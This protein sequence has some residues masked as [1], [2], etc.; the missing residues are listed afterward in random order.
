MT[1]LQLLS[2]LKYDHDCKNTPSF[3]KYMPVDKFTDKTANGLEKAIVMW[4]NLH[5]GMA[6]RRGNTGRYIDDS[7]IVTD[8]LGFKHKLGK[9]KYIPGTGT[10]GTSDVSGLYNGIPLAIEVKI[11]RDRQSPAQVEYGERFNA[12][13]GKYVVVKTFDEFVEFWK[14]LLNVH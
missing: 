1:N 7:K 13:G 10:N 4:I 12:A 9:G 2:K 14:K 11:G 8:R 5:G 3:A 6:E